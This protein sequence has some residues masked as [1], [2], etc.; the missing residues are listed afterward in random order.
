METKTTEQRVRETL[1]QV[2]NTW[3][4][5]VLDALD[6]QGPTRFSVVRDRVPGI[7]HKMLTQTL[8]SLERDGL[9]KRE[10]FAQ[11]PPRVEYELTSMG[12]KLNEATCSFWKW[13]DRYSGK[14]EQARAAYDSKSSDSVPWLKPKPFRRVAG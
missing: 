8:R 5:L 2:A 12:E 11:V 6:Q 9:V 10:V 3:T 13:V 1:Q 7:T 4:L 14:V